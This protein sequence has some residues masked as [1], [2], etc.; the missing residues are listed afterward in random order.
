VPHALAVYAAK[1][2]SP[3]SMQ[4]TE[5]EPIPIGAFTFEPR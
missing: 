4:Q 2:S 3:A 5:A 1:A